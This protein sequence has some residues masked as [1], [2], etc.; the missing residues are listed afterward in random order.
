MLNF[1]FRNKSWPIALDIGAANIRM[2]QIKTNAGRPF[3]M[4]CGHWKFPPALV[5][6]PNVDQAQR[7]AA[8]V[9]AIREMLHTQGFKGRRVISTLSTSQML[10]KNVRLPHLSEPELREA[11]TWEA[12]E[13]FAFDVKPDQLSFIN[14]GQVRQ[15]NEV[16]DE[17]IMLAAPPEAID[18]HLAMLDEIGLYA[19]SIDAE[20]IAIF[21][22]FERFLRRAVDE[23]AVSVV[24]DIGMNGTRIV[25]ARGRQIIFIKNI[26]IG[27]RRF[28]E[29]VSKQLNV[30]YEEACDL[31]IR[32]MREGQG[33]GVPA[34]EQE[35]TGA[36][37]PNSV[38]WTIHDALR[39][40]VE[41]AAREIALCLRYCSVTFRGLHPG[42]L[43][44]TGGEAYDPAVIRL[45][46]EHLG[47]E[48]VVG[49]PLRG[50][51]TSEV[52][53]GGDRRGMLSEW[54]VCAGMAVKGMEI[55]VQQQAGE[56][57]EQRLIA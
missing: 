48:C 10:V 3:V 4:A 39:A 18:A 52:D 57:K 50:V 14:A 40:E 47:V 26:D 32:I 37:D 6:G 41:A 1:L 31:R 54:A 20:P 12:K 45:L 35:L 36:K 19:D 22:C 17:I 25:M 15:G 43:T 49:Q 30:S 16:R 53:L 11:V 5:A 13:R 21:R 46:S 56:Q 34:G 33:F 42:N 2:L 9:A 8:A 28:T 24:L 27:G 44:I 7:K 38:N 55:P 23:T 29:A 51:D